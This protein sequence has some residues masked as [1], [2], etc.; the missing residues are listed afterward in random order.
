[1]GERLW[2]RS[3]RPIL[4]AAPAWTSRK[5]GAAPENSAFRHSGAKARWADAKNAA[6][7]CVPHAAQS[8]LGGLGRVR[9]GPDRPPQKSRRDL[10]LKAVRVF[11]PVWIHVGERI[12]AA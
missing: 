1:M 12:R 2:I 4:H 9:A 5:R 7:G 10:Y 8:Q 6:L 11:G 3:L